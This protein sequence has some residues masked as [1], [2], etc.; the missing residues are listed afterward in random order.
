MHKIY[1]Y[2]NIVNVDNLR[3]TRMCK[4]AYPGSEGKGHIKLSFK[5]F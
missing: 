4:H 5:L 3:K 1:K 2:G